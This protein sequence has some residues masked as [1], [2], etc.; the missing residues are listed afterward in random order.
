MILCQVLYVT[1]DNE[2]KN[3]KEKVDKDKFDKDKFDIEK[4][5]KVEKVEKVEKVDSCSANELAVR[6]KRI[7]F[8]IG[9]VCENVSF[10]ETRKIIFQKMFSVSEVIFVRC[11][12]LTLEFRFS[13]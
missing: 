3:S 6:L 11:V 4:V 7:G 12:V 2:N 8:D 10:S 13:E 9:E 5:K 1:D